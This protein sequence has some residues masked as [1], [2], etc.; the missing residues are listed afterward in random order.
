MKKFEKDIEANNFEWLYNEYVT[1]KRS[2]IS[3][4][5]ELG[6]SPDTIS[7]RLRRFNITIRDRGLA[8][9]L[10]YGTGVR[11]TITDLLVKSNCNKKTGRLIECSNCGIRFYVT[12]KSNRVFCTKRCFLEFKRNNRIPQEDSHDTPEYRE[13][14]SKVYMRDFWRCQVC[15]SKLKINSHHIFESIKYPDIRYEVS[16]GIVLCEKHHIQLH[17]YPSSFIQ[18]CIK[19]TSNIGETPEVD[20][21]EALIKEFLISLIRSND[22]QEES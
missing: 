13:W 16:N 4:A 20:N 11:H 15:G 5:K 21:P 22:Y 9:R 18:E 1:K 10:G 19:Q 8:N 14:R 3:I 17:K 12:K 7:T 2:M 6:V